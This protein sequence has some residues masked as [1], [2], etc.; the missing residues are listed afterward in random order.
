M[1]VTRRRTKRRV[2]TFHVERALA[3][4]QRGSDRLADRELERKHEGW[5]VGED[6]R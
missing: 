1:S 3:I 4:V 2:R 6:A 5:P